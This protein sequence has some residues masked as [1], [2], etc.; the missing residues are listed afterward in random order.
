MASAIPGLKIAPYW[1]DLSTGTNGNVNYWSYQGVLY[2]TWNVTVPKNT[3]GP[4]NAV[5]QVR[6][7]SAG[8]IGFYYGTTLAAVP[9]NPGGYSIGIG[10]TSPDFASLTVTSPT[11][12]TGAYGTANDANTLSI[13]GGKYIQFRPDHTAP[14]ISAETIANESGTANRT[15]TKTI[16]ETDSGPNTGIPTT[17]SFVPRIY[18]KKNAG[19]TWVSTAG[20]ISAG[21]SFSGTW[22][23][24]VNHSLVGGVASGDQI[25]YYV[26]AQDQS[27]SFG[28]PNIKFE[29]TNTGV[30]ATDVNTVTTPPTSPNS[31]VIPI[32]LTGTKTVGTNGDFTS[33]TNAGG[34]FD[35]LN[36]GTLTE[37]F[38]VNII[39]DLP[40]ETG[41]V[42]L[43]A[44]S[45]DAGGPYNVTIQPS[46]GARTITTANSIKLN[47]AKGLKIDGLND[48]TN[49]LTISSSSSPIQ[50]LYG[51]SNNTITRTTIEA[52]GSTSSGA[53]I[54][55]IDNSSSVSGN[56]NNTISYCTLTTTSASISGIYQGILLTN[57]YS[58]ANGTVI[59][60]NKFINIYRYTIFKDNNGKFENTVISNNEI[61]NTK[62]VSSNRYFIGIYM[63][64]AGSTDI[65]NNKIHNILFSSAS[66]SNFETKGI[67]CGTAAGKI[68][69]V[70]NN[71]IFFD[72]TLTH[73]ANNYSAIHIYNSGTTNISY[74]SIYI[75]GED[76]I[77]NYASYG[78]YSYGS[79]A[80][81]IKNNAVY[82]ARSNSTGTGKYYA[83]YTTGTVTSDYND[84]FADGTGG[85][86]GY[87]GGDRLTL[88]NWQAATS[89][90]ANSVPGPGIY[91]TD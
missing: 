20:T 62:A 39:S 30:A 36:Q 23:F 85:Y 53:C 51:A 60:H 16:S 86:I 9:A 65:F 10:N 55:K 31:Y 89:Q 33:L 22:D 50:I 43:N 34:L 64:N 26:I 78:I 18:F 28:V 12:F 54:I 29:P 13:G 25:F 74:N 77:G 15:L 17:G 42:S 14:T 47:G 71:E 3:T 8:S 44:W 79:V 84:L 56:N 4:A 73:N 87:K 59:D 81:V 66:A 46:G 63:L 7:S 52:Y 11:T 72:E 38:T 21:D 49:S 32:D 80:P 76:I 40:S 75:G 90:D 5:F 83:I 1:D 19:G 88:A 37:N 48:G 41:T 61:Y 45:E 57:S 82:I 67:F 58:T 24:T 68:M 27:T 35:Q 69:N 2:I 6:I 91:F 70:Y